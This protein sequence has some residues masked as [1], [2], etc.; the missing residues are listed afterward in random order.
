MSP[1]L[2]A[3]PFLALSFG[4][5]DTLLVRWTHGHR[6][7]DRAL[8]WQTCLMWLAYGALALIPAALVPWWRRR[9]ARRRDLVP[10]AATSAET[11]AALAAWTGGPV[12]V[13]ARIN[14]HT[15]I[16]GDV[17]GLL[18]FEAL[19]DLLVAALAI[20]LL[21][22]VTRVLLTR[23]GGLR[24]A[25]G[26]T[27]ASLAAGLLLSFHRAP[28]ATHAAV[29]SGD[30]PNV[31]LLVWD[32]TRSPSLSLHG[33]DRQ[34][35]PHLARL[36]E[37]ALVFENARSVSSY[38]F[39]SHLS[40]LTGVYPS[41]HGARLV[42]Q[43]FSPHETPTVVEDFARA[44]YRTGAF[45]GTGV[46]RAQTGFAWAFEEFDDLVDPP[47]CDTFGWAVL[48]DVQS[49]L[50]ELVPALH[51]NGLPHWFQ[52]F[53]RPA[54]EVLRSAAA[55]IDEPDPRPWFCLVNLYDVHWPY[56][57]DDEA[58]ERWVD[59]YDGPIDG[60]LKRGDDFGRHKLALKADPNQR[61]VGKRHVAQLYDAEMWDLDRVVDAFLR[62]L[63]LDR[64]AILMTSDHGVAFGEKG[65][66][67]HDGILECQLRVP[68]V[69]RPPGGAPGGRRIDW[70]V[71][72]IDVGPTLLALAGIEGTAGEPTKGDVPVRFL[73]TDL[74]KVAEDPP[75]PRALLVEDRD[76][77]NHEDIRLA[78]YQDQ[79]KLVR[80]GLGE[81]TAWMLYD[82]A[83]D[84]DGFEN[85]AAEH[86]EVVERLAER[87][88]ELRAVWG[89]D[90]RED[91]EAGANDNM[92]ALKAL[93]YAGS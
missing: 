58:R 16:G 90:D 27:L 48:H 11:I 55:W 70:P 63:D 59:P 44:G 89:V 71:S 4:A 78:L 66:W 20:W 13:H 79:W 25:G 82:L 54:A 56:V 84:P 69:V 40:M 65:R 77:L 74:L 67:E 18:S 41:H 92:D 30:R 45:V 28:V 10:A 60:Y 15:N 22:V 34:T 64:T 42:R 80:L 86:P 83:A 3:L 31:L 73:G 32:T 47:V 6:E 51:N 23:L 36:A 62:G 49:V 76:H 24:L 72:G 9:R 37:D 26:L 46:L 68:F 75:R 35:T 52:D 38:T 14:R 93:G 17:S 85:I 19:L 5:L 7:L 33:Y 50:A 61:E 12:L 43:T 21:I 39:T 1:R 57:P 81:K 91:S 53:Q 8:F 88:N 87:L 2:A 29:D